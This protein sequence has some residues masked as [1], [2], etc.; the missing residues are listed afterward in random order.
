MKT[1]T[2]RV[3]VAL[4]MLGLAGS[5]LAADGPPPPRK[6]RVTFAKGASAA[7]VKGTLKGG[8]DVDYLVRAAAGQTLEV[9]LQGTNA[10]NDFNVLPPGRPT[11]RCS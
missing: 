2:T 10:Q 9:K 8:D 1:I 11:S 7:T 5:V 4:A 6:E 3:L